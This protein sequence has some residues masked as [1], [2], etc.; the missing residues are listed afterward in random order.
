MSSNLKMQLLERAF[1]EDETNLIAFLDTEQRIQWANRT[2]CRHAGQDLE[3]LVG[4]CCYQAG[5]GNQTPCQGCPVPLTLQT[6]KMH[7]GEVQNPDGRFWLVKSYPLYSSDGELEGAAEVALDITQRKLAEEKSRHLSRALAAIRNVN[8]LITQERDRNRLIGEACNRLIE[9]GGYTSVWISLIEGGACY[10]CAEAGLGEAFSP[11]RARLRGGELPPCA[12]E[13]LQRSEVVIV[14]NGDTYCSECP[15]AGVPL[16]SARIAVPL[17]HQGVGYGVMAISLPEGYAADEKEWDL[18]REVANDLAFALRNIDLEEKRAQAEEALYQSESFLRFTLD[19]LS[20]HIAVLDEQGEIILVNRA[21][22]DFAENNGI[23]AELVS[24]GCNY[25][26]VCTGSTGDFLSEAESF[27]EGIQRVV[28][29]EWDFFAR[30]YPCHSPTHRRWFYGR[31]T[32]FSEAPPRRVVVAHLEITQRVEAEEQLQT[33]FDHAPLIMLLVDSQG[34][35]RKSN[36]HTSRFVGRNEEDIQ[37]RC[38]GEALRCLHYLSDS[39]GCGSGPQCAQCAIRNTV[40]ET[41]STGESSSHVEARMELSRHGQGQ[42]CTFLLSTTLLGHQEDWLVLVGLMD[43]TEQKRAYEDLSHHQLV[44]STLGPLARVFVSL[45]S[46]GEM[47]EQVLEAGRN[48]TRS[49]YGFVGTLDS[50]SGNLVAHTMT[51]T[52]WDTCQVPN[53]D[54]VFDRFCGLWGWVLKH[55]KPILCNSPA[56]D[57]RSTGV[58]QGHI[59]ISNFLSVPVFLEQELVGI[60]ALANSEREYTERDL[61]VIQQ[62]GGFFAFAIQRQSYEAELKRAKEQ[63]EAANKAKTEFLNN[64]SHELRTPLNAIIGFSDLLQEP[65]FGELNEEQLEYVKYISQ[66]GYHLL[67]LINDILD[68]SKVDADKMSLEP[69]EIQIETFLRNMIRMLEQKA[70]THGLSMNLETADELAQRIVHADERKLRQI[71]FNLLSNA[72]KNTPDGGRISVTADIVRLETK[73][74]PEAREMLRVSVADTGVGISFQNQERIFERFS[75]LGSGSKEQEGTGLGLALTKR[76]VELHG[77]HI[78]VQSEGEG[79]GSVFTFQIPMDQEEEGP[80]DQERIEED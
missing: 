65:A 63:A 34:R 24:E 59:P 27:A 9:T 48:L 70:S 74:M 40:R 39:H 35:I 3:S 20:S 62:L 58:P 53:K 72:T 80:V 66:G 51:R 46:F 78:F 13:A 25:L 19:G 21:W 8:Q 67:D 36:A 38:A 28:S 14:R 69:K 1:F 52:V 37:G 31:V 15:L 32:P 10:A 5:P 45:D 42:E 6:G 30:E 17:A 29:G 44:E 79:K 68:L 47:C 50:Q 76:L 56:E 23:S 71:L 75:Q 4:K 60:I 12:R 49:S 61:Q 33:I 16:G 41:L 54:F 55:R 26:A 57:P 73:E 11:L 77:G 2:A 22:R 43:I 7:Q 18:V 64:M